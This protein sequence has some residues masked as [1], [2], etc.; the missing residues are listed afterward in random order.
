MAW[1]TQPIGP[2]KS[3]LEVNGGARILDNEARRR[4]NEP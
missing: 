4:V 2:L 1:M 3:N